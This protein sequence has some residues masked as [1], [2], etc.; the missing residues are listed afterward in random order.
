[1]ISLQ[2]MAGFGFLKYS[3]G[4]ESRSHARVYLETFHT[5]WNTILEFVYPLYSLCNHFIFYPLCPGVTLRRTPAFSLHNLMHLKWWQFFFQL[6][7]RFFQNV[8]L[9]L[10]I[11]PLSTRPLKSAMHSLVEHQDC[12]AVWLLKWDL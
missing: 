7:S 3:C 1:M 6:N 10:P 11:I 2:G 8:Q 9:A 4:L 12:Q 5:L